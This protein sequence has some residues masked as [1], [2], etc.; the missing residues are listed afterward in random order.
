MG[1]PSI[2]PENRGE[3]SFREHCISHQFQKGR[4]QRPVVG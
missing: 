3:R 2:A 1:L 4:R